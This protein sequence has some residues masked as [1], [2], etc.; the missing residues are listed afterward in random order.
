MAAALNRR[1]PHSPLAH[2][3]SS[4]GGNAGLACVVAAVELGCAAT[5]VVPV[6]TNPLI[7]NKI[8]DAGA[9]EVIQHGTCWKE[10][11]TYLKEVCLKHDPEGVYVP[12]FDHEDIW[13]GHSTI[14]RELR[15]QLNPNSTSTSD[16]QRLNGG[17][18]N[19]AV[20]ANSTGVV[21]DAIVCSVGGGGLFS[22]IMRELD[23]QPG[24]S[25]VPVIAVETEGAA[26]LAASLA[27]GKLVTLPAITSQAAT[28]GASRVAEQTFKY[29]S[30]RPNVRSAVLSDAEAG[31]GCVKLADYERIM[32]E[33]ACGVNVA[34]CFG[35][36]LETALGRSLTKQ[37]VVVVIVCGGSNV[38]FDMLAR[39]RDE[40]AFLE[41]PLLEGK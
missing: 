6:T 32:V 36:R 13:E 37:D 2:F 41:G 39:W 5:V 11:D 16:L 35:Q 22:G 14:V 28:L 12:P 20:G 31:M 23:R 15:K 17:F 25:H 4:S 3:Y 21:P 38:T 10:A 24:W 8:R 29:A 33:L 30:T 18:V 27:A 9:E 26:S 40:H 7:L 19:G 1:R 34:M